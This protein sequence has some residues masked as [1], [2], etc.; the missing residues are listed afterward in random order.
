MEIKTVN[1]MAQY[2]K[3]VIDKY[4]SKEV[5]RNDTLA[6]IENLFKIP[7]NRGIAMRGNKFTPS[8]ER[9]LGKKRIEEL[10]NFLSEIDKELYG[11]L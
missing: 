1:D 11:D 5:S 3:P 2:I 6:E 9:K 10:K 4:W 8:F 7:K